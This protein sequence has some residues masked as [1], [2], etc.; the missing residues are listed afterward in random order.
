MEFRTKINI[1]VSNVNISHQ[2]KILL[3]GSCFTE[4]IGKYLLRNKFDAA[5]N[6]FGILYNPVSLFK[7]I[8]RIA[9]NYVYTESDLIHFNELYISLEHH[10]QFSGIDKQQVLQRIN[11]TIKTANNHFNASNIV[12]I[13]L[14]T[15]WVYNYKAANSIVANCHKIPNKNFDKKILAVDE[16][17]AAFETSLP[18]LK[19][20]QVIFTVSPVRHWRDGAIENQQSKSILIT[21]IHQLHKQYDFISYFPSYE[22][23]MDELRDYRFYERD[24]L[25]PN[26]IAIQYIWELF[27]ETYF[28]VETRQLNTQIEKL[29][30]FMDHRIKQSNTKEEQE[31]KS[32]I[33]QEL[34]NFKISHP[35]IG[36]RF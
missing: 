27:S 22:I 26:D 19:N 30:L 31:H 17:L 7:S 16:V 3:A 32:K 13:T 21:A 4:N 6:P 36:E 29:N 8:E 2:D 14:G 1:P 24:M 34:N 23:L 5:L 10:G 15:A 9:S 33:Q 20:K 11:D 18:F 35:E 25:H 12:I 28:S